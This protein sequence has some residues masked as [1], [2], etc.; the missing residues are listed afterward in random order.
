M[1]DG[2]GNGIK[3]QRA[4]MVADCES[5]ERNRGDLREVR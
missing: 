1:T 5:G 2:P 4:G 3:P